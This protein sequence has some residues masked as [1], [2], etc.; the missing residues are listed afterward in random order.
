MLAKVAVRGLHRRPLAN[1]AVRSLS[2]SGLKEKLIDIMPAKQEQLKNFKKA[3]GAK[4]VDRVTID[5]LVGGARSI[6]SM[7]WDTSLLDPLEGIRFRGFTIPELQEKLPS[8]T[9]KPGAE[10]TPEAPSGCCLPAR[11]RQRRRPTRSPRSC[12]RAPS[13]PRTWRP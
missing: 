8:Y 4:I 10:P 2:S 13:C 6:K 5:Q 7:L 1:V 11:C 3:H 12:T 9:G